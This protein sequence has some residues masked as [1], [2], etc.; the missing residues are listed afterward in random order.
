MAETAYKFSLRGKL[1]LFI[2][3]LAII[4]YSTS[5]FFMYV[6]YPS[7][8]TIVE[9]SSF[10]FNII[11]L[12]LGIFWSGV[13]AYFAA[14][15]ITKPLKRLEK[16]AL[17]VAHG[18][19]NHDVELAKSNDE[20]K[21]L[22]IAFNHM[23]YNLREM[24]QHIEHNFNKTNNTVQTIE[25]ESEKAKQQIAAISQAMSEIADGA[26]V[27]AQSV[28]DA[29]ELVEDSMKIAYQVE[30][31]ASV[32]KDTSK[33]MLNVLAETKESVSSLIE[34]LKGLVIDNKSSL[35]SVKKLESHS[36]EI[37]EIIKIV[38]ELAAQT[39]LLAL[40]ASIEAARAGD[41]GAGFSVVAEEVR[42]LADESGHAVKGISALINSMQGEVNTV[43][44]KITIQLEN[45]Q[46]KA[47]IGEETNAI[48]VG[49]NDTI[50]KMVEEIV[51]ITDLIHQQKQQICETSQ[52]SQEVAAISEETS[53]GAYQVVEITEKQTI[54][55]QIIGS[56]ILE[57]QTNAKELKETISRFK[58]YS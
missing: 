29:S 33:K 40:N 20:V 10:V 38:G 8:S 39:N 49:M 32:L 1:A 42:R 4:T 58:L 34:G 9:I 57:L 54:M 52:Q 53:A 50:E 31:K 23:L 35:Q 25:E 3:L 43:V 28:Q 17:Q 2:T 5:A 51:Q 21:S 36:L 47:G 13:L 6:I 56:L 46:K 55:I 19:I 26:E 27:S 44:Q 12:L 18:D 7:V 48:F 11:T 30:D 15:F 16:G 14:S 37:G 45:A 41:H 22:G 24:V